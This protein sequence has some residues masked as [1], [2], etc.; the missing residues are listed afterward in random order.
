MDSSLAKI[1]QELSVAVCLL[2]F[3]SLWDSAAFAQSAAPKNGASQPLSFDV[4]TIKPS[5]EQHMV[6][7][8]VFPGGRV[9]IGGL[10]L[11]GLIAT[12]F[13]LGYWQISGGDEWTG[14]V[15]YDLEA[16]PAEQLREQFTNIRHSLFA[17]DDPQLREML[18]SL[19][20]ERFQLK[21]HCETKTGDVYLLERSGKSIK[22]LPSRDLS[23][24]K[25][26]RV[27]PGWSGDI[28]FVNGQFSLYNTSMPQLA[29]FASNDVVH[30]QV[31]DRT[32]LTGSYDFTSTIHAEQSDFEN[33]FMLLIPELGLKLERAKGPVETFVID[34]AEMPSPN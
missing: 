9:Q 6:G 3:L 31:I 17:I 28:D 14:K 21:F 11:K 5:P 33:T 18:Q 32:G 4:A 30:K 27:S 26:A 16:K 22:L 8:D 24:G 7:V 2:L 23:T 13:N 15:E 12:A 25:D 20:I 34:H 1:P 10:S 29:M 19:L